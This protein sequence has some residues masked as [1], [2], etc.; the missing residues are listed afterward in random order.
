MQE[1]ITWH[2]TELE[3]PDDETTVLMIDTTGDYWIGYH[4]ADC[5]YDKHGDILSE[6][7]VCWSDLPEGKPF[8]SFGE[9]KQ[10]ELLT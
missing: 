8:F 7:V 5:W 10:C 6:L 3:M 4:D 1:I 9:K 2:S